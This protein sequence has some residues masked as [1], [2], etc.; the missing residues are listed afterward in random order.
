[1]HLVNWQV[2][3]GIITVVGGLVY[4]GFWTFEKQQAYHA[5]FAQEEDVRLIGMRLDEKISGDR[6]KSYQQEMWRLEDRYGKS[7]LEGPSG[8]RSAVPADKKQRYRELK[9]L[10]QEELD[11]LKRTR[12][13]MDQMQHK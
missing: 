13:K 7:A 12:D 3:G 2:A 1:M 4:G 6:A 9:R 11:R 5:Q 10:H 8:T